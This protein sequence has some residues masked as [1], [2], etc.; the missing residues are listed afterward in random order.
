MGLGHH[1]QGVVWQWFAVRFSERDQQANSKWMRTLQEEHYETSCKKSA[2]RAQAS[3][4]K[5]RW[6]EPQNLR[7]QNL[8][9]R[10]RDFFFMSFLQ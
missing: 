9:R 5:I 7:D 10:Y 8:R 1:L 2:A 3:R 4:E 6:T